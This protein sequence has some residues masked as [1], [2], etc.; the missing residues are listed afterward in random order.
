VLFYQG[1]Q[2]P[3]RYK[4]G[5][6]IAFHGSTNRAPYPQAGYF[7]CFVPFRDGKPSGDWEVFADGFAGID[8]I[9]NVSDAKFRPMGLAEGPD[10]S[11]YISDSRKGKVWRVMFKGDRKSFGV[12]QLATMEK[13][14]QLAHIR[15]PD[16]VTDN[17]DIKTKELGQRIYN[18][19]C[20][21]CHQR[22]GQGD[23]SRFPP[24]AG[25]EW[26]TGSKKRL[27]EVVAKGLE[28]P[29]QVAGKPYND[30]MPKH[31]FLKPEEMAQVLTYIRKNFG[32]NA[33]AISISDV[34]RVLGN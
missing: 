23:G 31:D 15:T 30:L 5:A 22:N 1:N 20:T 11:L 6:F 3:E 32:N 12:K 33:D 2:F 27:I 28:G 7:V 14:K 4:N 13:H 10:G 34:Q 8:P 9:I 24:L 17:L 19:Y 18:T 26:V 25:S 16:E 29:I 21:P